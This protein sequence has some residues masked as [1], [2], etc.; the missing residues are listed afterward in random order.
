M[1]AE[2][3]QW[4]ERRHQGWSETLYEGL[5]LYNLPFGILIAR[6]SHG[7]RVIEIYALADYQF[8]ELPG[9]AVEVSKA[10]IQEALQ[11]LAADKK[12][13]EQVTEFNRLMG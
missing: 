12:L 5:F 10:F 8:V 11:A 13:Q 2:K 3:R 1:K 6:L 7:L 9:A 4:R